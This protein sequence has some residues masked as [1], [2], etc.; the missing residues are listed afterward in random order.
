MAIHSFAYADSSFIQHYENV[1]GTS[2]DIHIQGAT[3]EHAEAA[4]QSTLSEIERLEN[5]LSTWR[6]N[7]Q[8]SQLNQSHKL[9][10]LPPELLEVIQL[11][12]KWHSL[13]N[14]TFSCRLGKVKQIWQQAAEQQIVP[15]RVA[16]RYQARDIQRAEVKISP[17]HK[18]VDLGDKIVLDPSGIAKGFII[19]KAVAHLHNLLPAAS[20]IKIDIGGDAFYWQQ[21]QHEQVWKVAI[22][23]PLHTIDTTEQPLFTLNLSSMAVAA[24]GHSSRYVEIQR[25]KFSHILSAQD[26]WPQDNAPAATVIA[27]DAATADAIATALSTQSLSTGIDWVNQLED[28]EALLVLPNG[29]KVASNGWHQYVATDSKGSSP[30][31]AVLEIEYQIPV[32]EAVNYHKPYLAIWISD[33]KNNSVR[34]LL[35]LGESS[36]WA[37]ENSRWW[38]RVG[39]KNENLLDGLARPTRRPGHYQVSWDGLNDA[40]QIASPGSYYLN[41][42]AA[43]EG[44]GHDYQRVTFSY[45]QQTNDPQLESKQLQAKGEM[46]AVHLQIQPQSTAFL[47]TVSLLNNP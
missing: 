43:R 11:C 47:P 6:N 38:R 41:I 21:N 13:S 33:S 23:D 2:M 30:A 10:G 25:R 27:P 5:I 16:L 24:S 20:A 7:S 17:E 4:I 9:A 15:D 35:L 42:E 26:G 1:L 37:K 28:V 39:R 34:N 8:I 32:L 31:P 22:A 44:G 40:G 14:K 18:Q 19:D 3:T 46:G 29:L 45:N 36:R 12:E